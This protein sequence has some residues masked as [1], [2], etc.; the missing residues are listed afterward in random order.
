LVTL[1]TWN[2]LAPTEVEALFPAAMLPVLFPAPMLPA[3]PVRLLVAPAWSLGLVP[4]VEELEP[5]LELFA[6]APLAELL[7][8][9]LIPPIGGPVISTCSPMCVRRESRL[10]VRL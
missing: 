1:L 10:P 4:V 2:E 7:A 5:M 9:A 6:A 3:V 8:E